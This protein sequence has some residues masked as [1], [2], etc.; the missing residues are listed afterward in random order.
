MER[1]QFLAGAAAMSLLPAA[2]AAAQILPGPGFGTPLGTRPFAPDVYRARRARLMAELKTGLA[3]IHGATA[4]GAPDNTIAAPFT[5]NGD[6]AW[7]TG[8]SDEP[9]AVLVLAP[10]EAVVK[11]FLFLPSRDVETERWEVERLPLGSLIEQRTG[12]QRV[13]RTARL[14]GVVTQL[15]TRAKELHFL[16]PVVSA[17]AP[18]PATLELYSKVMARVPGTS[19]RDQSGLLT[20]MRSVKEPRELEWLNK[21]M[22]A[23]RAGHLAAMKAV[24]PGMTER[25]LRRVLEEGFAN[26]GGTGIAYNSIVAA[27]RNAASLHYVAETGPIRDGDLVLIDAAAAVD[28]YACDVTRTF[29]AN[30][31][32]TAT[33]RADYEL[34]LAA[35]AAAEATLKAGVSYDVFEDAAKQVFRRAGRIDDFIH[36]LGHYV[37]L[38]VHD[39]FDRSR[40]IPAGAVIT[41]EPGLYTQSANQGIRIEDQYLVTAAGSE[42]MSAGIPRS[43]AEIEAAMRG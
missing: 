27:G 16:G 33:Q 4:F 6:F 21:A 12:V 26:A 39:P 43:I 25:Q 23:T 7:L 10:G 8:I 42:R 29:P 35:Q 3:V 40:P 17:D 11:E 14:G 9:G 20:Q 13:Q 19:I 30:G 18:V 37:G 22:V 38:D 36:G 24:K 5:Q 15:A 31:R 1:R 28:G 41:I 32:F 34:V 2:D